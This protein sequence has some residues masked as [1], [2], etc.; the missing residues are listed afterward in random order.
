MT[1][2]SVAVDTLRARS[3]SL[4]IASALSSG[5]VCGLITLGAVPVGFMSLFG[6]LPSLLAVGIL[7]IALLAF[8]AG[9]LDF[10]LTGRRA[11]AARGLL[12]TVA[13]LVGIGMVLIGS[14][15]TGSW[16]P[17]NALVAA[18]AVFGLTAGTTLLLSGRVA[19]ALAGLVVVVVTLVV[20]GFVALT[21]QSRVASESQ[22][23]EFGARK[24]PWTIDAEG[25]HWLNVQVR[26]R[27]VDDSTQGVVEMIYLSD[28]IPDVDPVA[29][30]DIVVRTRALA[31]LWWS[32][33]VAVSSFEAF[34]QEPFR[35]QVVE[36]CEDRG[37][38]WV[39]IGET[40]HTVARVEGLTQIAVTADR[41]VDLDLLSR[42]LDDARPLSAS[43]HAH[44]VNWSTVSGD[45]RPDF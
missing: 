33:E 12:V 32:P 13:A 1:E 9:G 27:M 4:A 29:P 42:L 36:S 14:A 28:A 3:H 37:D 21:E 20:F 15:T 40:G 25:Y 5:V 2:E 24:V 38:T 16:G 26:S 11:W 39:Q 45:S 8:A 30:Q 18:V 43:D 6:G 41:T 17:A 34:C 23:V 7:T 35:E 10:L 22:I 44:L 31:E 19:T